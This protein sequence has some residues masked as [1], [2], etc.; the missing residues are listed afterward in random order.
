MIHYTCD[1]CHRVIDDSEELRFE[2]NIVAEVKLENR[3]A[4]NGEDGFPQELD[5]LLDSAIDE[6]NEELLQSQRFDLCAEC[7][8]EY[9]RNPLGCEPHVQVGFSE[10]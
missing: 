2:V 9:S 4:G 3:G 1:R 10:N 8:L 7:Y 5:D 6:A